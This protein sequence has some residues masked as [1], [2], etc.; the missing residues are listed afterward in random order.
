MSDNNEEA[1]DLWKKISI[2]QAL[3]KNEGRQLSHLIDDVDNPW[4]EAYSAGW[5][6][7][8]SL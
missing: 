4:F 2:N 7:V 3:T 1:W 5:L 6:T 8:G